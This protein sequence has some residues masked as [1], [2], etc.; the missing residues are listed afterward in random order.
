[1]ATYTVQTGDTLFAIAQRY[2]VT[3]EAIVQAN[4]ITNPNVIFVGQ[5]LT[6][7]GTGTGETGGETGPGEGETGGGENE[8]SRRIG[9]LLYTISTDKRTYNRGENV[10]IALTKTNTGNRDVILRYRTAQ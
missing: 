5:V 1:M 2:G 10:V 8:V 6:I 3:V 4:S 9:N 7:P